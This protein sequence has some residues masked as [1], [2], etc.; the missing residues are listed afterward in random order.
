MVSLVIGKKGR[1]ILTIMSESGTKINVDQK[2]KDT[3]AQYRKVTIKGGADNIV[4]ASKLVVRLVEQMSSK[5]HNVDYRKRPTI[6]RSVKAKAKLVL[7]KD[8][9]EEVLG[10]DGAFAYGL[11]KQFNVDIEVY[12]EKD[13]RI[14]DR[15][16]SIL[17]I[18]LDSR[19]SRAD[20][21]I[22]KTH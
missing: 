22:F 2:N 17:V 11:S 12:T 3:P 13:S 4:K 6:D 5:V 15:D 20:F 18:Y 9:E 10:V 21:Q 8:A 7:P 16:D 1:Q 19:G 14:T